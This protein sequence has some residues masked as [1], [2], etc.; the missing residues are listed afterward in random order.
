MNQRLSW[1]LI[2]FYKFS[3]IL[4][5]LAIQYSRLLI[6]VSCVLICFCIFNIF[7]HFADVISVYLD[8][9][10][11]KT[12]L[13]LNIFFKF[14]KHL[15]LSWTKRKIAKDDHYLLDHRLRI[16]C[17]KERRETCVRLRR[18]RVWAKWWRDRTDKIELKI[19]CN[20]NM[21]RV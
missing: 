18:K 21:K 6:Q 5:C 20:L 14:K 8:I 17:N 11:E 12:Q 7:L 3:I 2:C 19:R 4:F 1:F 16:R 9:K 13:F 10:N 15:I